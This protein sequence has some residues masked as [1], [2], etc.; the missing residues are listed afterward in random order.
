[1]S[2]CDVERERHVLGVVI[3]GLF[4][5]V[6]LGLFRLLA[7]EK[8]VDVF[9]VVER[10]VKEEAQFGNDAQLVAQS[11]AE[12]VSDSFLVLSDVFQDFFTFLRREDA[13]IGCADAEVWRYFGACDADDDAV[14]HSRLA[15][16][17]LCEFLLYQSCYAIFSGILHNI[18]IIRC[19]LA[20][21]KVF[22]ENV[23][24]EENLCVF[25][26]L[27]RMFGCQ[28]VDASAFGAFPLYVFVAL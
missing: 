14:C 16:E 23:L 28:V 3:G 11:C 19:G 8:A 15:L 9:D 26:E 17:N 6:A 12:L 18:Y 27:L 4:V 13:Q 7:A 25:L 2:S 10:V 24:V 22:H 5:L 20:Q 21:V 1:M